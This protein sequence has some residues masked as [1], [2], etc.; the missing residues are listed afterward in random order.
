MN[1]GHVHL[2]E[3]VREHVAVVVVRGHAEA[4]VRPD[5][6]LHGGGVR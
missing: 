2:R 3:L 4:P 6:Q 1:P 5:H